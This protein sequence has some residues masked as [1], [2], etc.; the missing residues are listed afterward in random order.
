MVREELVVIRVGGIGYNGLN[1]RG[2]DCNQ[3]ITAGAL[4]M[5]MMWL[6]RLSQLIAP[7]PSSSD[8]VDD[9]KCHEEIK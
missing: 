7:L 1:L 6:E 2:V 4:Q 8:D 9:A 5:V 3:L